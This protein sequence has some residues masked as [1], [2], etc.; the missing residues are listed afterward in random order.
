MN[1]SG[2]VVQAL[3]VHLDTVIDSLNTVEGTDV[4]YSDP[5]SGRVVATL[6]GSDIRAE[7]EI[8]KIIKMLPHVVYAEMVYH[9]FEEQVLRQAQDER[10]AVDFV[11][12]EPFDHAQESLVEPHSKPTCSD[13]LP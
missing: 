13:G 1:V 9:R 3:P 5:I 8:L 6:E 10:Q 11:R 12:G 4:H 2:I 7:V